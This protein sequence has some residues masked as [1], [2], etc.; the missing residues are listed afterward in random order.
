MGL[1][2]ISL[3]DA[4][5]TSDTLT[6]NL[7]D[8]E[9]GAATAELKATGIESVT[10]DLTD[11]TDTSL[12]GYTLDV[13]SINATTLTVTGGTL[14]TSGTLALTALDT[15]TTTLDASGYGGILT[16]TTATAIATSVTV[17]GDRAHVLTGSSKADTFTVGNTTGA[18]VTLDAGAGTDTLNMTL[19]D[20][21]QD[22]NLMSNIEN[23]NFTIAASAD[24]TTDAAATDLDGINTASSVTFSGGNVLS[25]VTLGGSTDTLTGDGKSVNTVLDFSSFNGNIADATFGLDLFDN[26]TTGIT[27]QVMGGSITTDTV[28]ASYDGDNSAAVQVNMQ[29]VELFDVDYGDSAT[30]V[31]MDMSLVTGLTEVNFIDLPTATQSSIQITNNVD[32][33]MIDEDYFA[34]LMANDILG[35]V[36]VGEKTVSGIVSSIGL[37]S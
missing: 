31:V 24:I 16:A 17:G 12:P 2:D 27:V 30:E 6:I 36:T 9:A 4:T 13:D 32:L 29:G 7:N 1:L 28:S 23:I 22:F 34:A 25:S 8:T 37:V 5:G 19:G 33:K 20:G 3:A 14:A 18:S 10:I 15:D 35:G 26:D 21:V 11:D